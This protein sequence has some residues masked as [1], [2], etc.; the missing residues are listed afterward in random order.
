[1]K[2][3]D[4]IVHF[5]Q[6]PVK[7]TLLG[8]EKIERHFHNNYE[9]IFVLSGNVEMTVDDQLVRLEDEDIYMVNAGS[10]HEIK[11]SGGCILNVSFHYESFFV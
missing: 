11:S 6:M 3:A 5:D 1:M 9:I 4:I 8:R 2:L 7:I 10:I